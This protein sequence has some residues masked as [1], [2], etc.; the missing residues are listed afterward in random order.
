MKIFLLSFILLLPLISFPQNNNYVRSLQDLHSPAN[1]KKFADFLFCSGDYL[2]SIDEYKK[3]LQSSEDDTVEFKIGLALSGMKKFSEAAD[4]FAQAKKKSSL[5]LQNEIECEKALLQA[6][7]FNLLRSR[8]DNASKSIELKRLNYLSYFYG[9]D[10]LPGMDEFLFAFPEGNRDQIKKLYE[11]KSSPPLKSEFTAVILSVLI[12]GAG[13]FYI[14]EYGDGIAAFAATVLFGYLSYDN[15][16][17][18]HKFRGWLFAGISAFFYAGN[19]Y[20]SAAG[21]PIYNAK[22]Y[23]DFYNNLNVYL[24]KQN[25]FLPEYG[26]CK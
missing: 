22:L 18:D 6:G 19:I 5:Y 9:N 13:K 1:I 8:N 12:P 25:Y 15:F 7:E 14:E 16:K 21:V 2:R 20:G 26:F 11:W 10:L 23:F 4:Y 3:Y 17:A 24:D